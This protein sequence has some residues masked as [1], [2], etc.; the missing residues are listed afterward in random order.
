MK[1]FKLCIWALVAMSACGDSA[2]P[3]ENGYFKFQFG[4]YGCTTVNSGGVKIATGAQTALI[5]TDEKSR[6]GSVVDVTSANGAVL[7]IGADFAMRD[8]GASITL[9]CTGDGGCVQAQGALGLSPVADGTTRLTFSVGGVTRDVLAVTAAAPTSM[10]VRDARTRSTGSTS[11]SIAN[12]KTITLEAVLK[13]SAGAD[14]A[15]TQTFSW[16]ASGPLAATSG[17][18]GAVAQSGIVLTSADG[19]TGTGDVTAHFGSFDARISVEAR[20]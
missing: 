1:R 7:P 15:A 8:A 19:G 12:D 2:H 10:I 13:D 5:V 14:L 16:T 4:L 17:A 18:V 11:F 3:G 20:P 6:M 9:N